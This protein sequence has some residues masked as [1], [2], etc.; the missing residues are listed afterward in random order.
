MTYACGVYFLDQDIVIVCVNC[1]RDVPLYQSDPVVRLPR[2]A[3]ANVLGGAALKVLSASSGVTSHVSSLHLP[4]GWQSVVKKARKVGV[5]SDGSRVTVVPTA[6][7]G[8]GDFTPLQDEGLRCQAQGT[9]LGETILCQLARC[10]QLDRQ[11]F[12]KELSLKVAPRAARSCECDFRPGA[13][14]LI[15]FATTVAGIGRACKPITRMDVDAS[16][17]SLG[18][19]VIAALT[20]EIE[21]YA[22]DRAE[23]NREIRAVSRCKNW[24]EFAQQARVISVRRDGS[25]ILATPYAP[26]REHPGGFLPL[27]DR[28]APCS[29]DPAAVGEL[30]RDLGRKIP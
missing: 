20:A 18:R 19:G 24:K 16:P 6:F 15:P 14:Y 23:Y 28:T 3:S 26:D 22:L 2:S 10:R 1:V 27:E 5:T 13:A 29:A 11:T 4:T 25:S 9:E 7:D 8:E 30:L 21:N 17:D 12:V